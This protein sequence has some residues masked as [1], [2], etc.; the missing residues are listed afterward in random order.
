MAD[1]EPVAQKPPSQP[2]Q[3]GSSLSPFGYRVFTV[4]WIATVVSNIGT[5]MQSATAGWLM[6]TLNPDPLV[7]AL[8][9]VA[10]SL[11]MFIFALPAGAL[12]DIID[13]RRLLIVIQ[14]LI[15]LLV[16]V[17][18]VLVWLEQV[19]PQLLL[20][21]TFLMG[22]ASAL[23][24]PA[25]QSI[26]PQLVPRQELQPAVALNSVGINVSRAIGP[27]LAGLIIAQWGLAAPFWVNALTTLGVI[28]ALIWWHPPADAARHLPPEH[29]GGAIRA[30]LRHVRFNP[31]L[32]ATSIR[33][34]SFFIFASA[35]WALL[36]L[37]ARHQI[38]GGPELYGILL[39]AI[40][41]GAVGGAFLLPPLKRRLGADRLVM[42]GTV[43]TAFAMILFGLA[44]HPTTALIA[45]VFAGVS[46]IAVLA[47]LNVSAQLGLPAW[48]RGR[49]LAVFVTVMFG[50]L[51][52][53]SYIWG[54][55][56]A[57]IGL[58]AAHI[59]AAVAALVSIPLLLPWK[60]QTG[61]GVDLTPS[62][63]W[64]A[65]VVSGDIEADR[66][67][68]LV[69]VEYQVDPAKREA[70]LQAIAPLAQ[71]RRRDG[72]F[73]WGIFEDAA[74]TGRFVE[75]FLLDSWMEHL[76][77]HERITN[78]DRVIQDAVQQ[79]QTAGA[80]TVRHLIAAEPAENARGI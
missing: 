26:V 63:H 15:T 32:R 49:G 42:A 7:V 61:A 43:G 47:T 16:C 56:A 2:A 30:G 17:F 53:G 48:V 68:V 31:H 13:R 38:H 12:A 8:V 3:E 58:S 21:F 9:Q 65:P 5:W 60:L 66:G 79:F 74:Q 27:A 18:G 54:H 1:A 76:R 40:G 19:T 34:A 35:Y 62:M 23:I 78:A 70:F 22:A 67:P 25:W 41:V 28:G 14:I 29:F 72:A 51:T 80:P 75:A 10:S 71:A 39:G 4:L 59:A 55:V 37:V 24:A 20:I 52:L 6:A 45:S 46:W 73:Q 69:S 11:P 36:P 77:Q 33:A 50:A 57:A 44:R 64:P